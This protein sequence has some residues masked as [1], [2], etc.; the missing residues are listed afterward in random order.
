MS[1]FRKLQMEVKEEKKFRSRARPVPASFAEPVY[2]DGDDSDDDGGFYDAFLDSLRARAPADDSSEDEDDEEDFKLPENFS[3]ESSDSDIEPGSAPIAP[4]SSWTTV[5]T[6]VQP[7]VYTTQSGL[8][9]VCCFCLS[10]FCSLFWTL[11]GY[12]FVG[13]RSVSLFSVSLVLCGI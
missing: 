8:S 3:E 13:T 1:F 10:V 7:A 4:P 6:P 5:L 9:Q 12:F 11:V 2:V